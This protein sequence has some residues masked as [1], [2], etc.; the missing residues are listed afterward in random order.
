MRAA[1]CNEFGAPLAVEEV[2]LEAPRAREVEVE[3][4]ACAICHSDVLAIDGAWG[5]V[6]PAVYG[7]EAAGRVAALGAGVAGLAVGDP[8]VVTLLRSC[9]AC[10]FC[11][12]GDEHLCEA[13]FAIGDETRLSGSDG[14]PVQQGFATGAFA[15]RVVVD[16]S[17]TVRLPEWVPLAS[18]ALL[19]CGVITGYGAVVNTA[20]VPPG[21]SVAVVG[22]GGV[23]LNS[24]QGAAIAGAAPVIAID[25]SAEKLEAARRF[26][27]SHALDAASG[28]LPAAVRALTGGRGVDYAFITAGSAAAAESGLGLLRRG[29]TLVLVGMPAS[30]V[31][32]GLEVASFAY[33]AQRVAGS[34][35]GATRLRVDVPRLVDLYGAGTLK[36]D[37]LI[38]GRFP[39]EAINAAIDGV[40]HGRSLRNVVVL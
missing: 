19:A 29:G 14:R 18:A 8:V 2:A 5:G 30:G 39:L 32:A 21:A 36:L 22:T 10:W 24:V 1:V 28:D 3:I 15:E 26:G 11:A 34:R 17:Q 40:R 37:E 6:L 23:G 31:K 7:H 12:R 33:D 9:G 35:M 27:A 4:A 20:A 13:R 16:A 38:S 25:L